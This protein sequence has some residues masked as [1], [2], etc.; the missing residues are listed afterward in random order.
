[1]LNVILSGVVT[2]LLYGLVGLSLVVVYRASKVMN[3]A[4]GGAGVLVAYVA[5]DLLRGGLPYWLVLPTCVAIG[6]LLGGLL[7]LLVARRMRHQA[8]IAVALATLGAMLMVEGAVG[9]HWGFTPSGLTPVLADSGSLRIGDVAVSAN[10]LF[11]IGVSIVATAL[12]LFLIQRTRFGLGMRAASSGPMT[13]ELMGLDV[14]RVRLSA[15]I[16][17]GAYGCLAALLVIPLTYLSPTSFTPFLL[18]AFAAVVLG[19]LT[20]VLGVV[21]GAVFFGVTVNL[22]AV[23]VQSGLIA[24]YTFIGVALILLFRP[25]GLF[26]RG[27]TEIDEPEL[28]QASGRGGG[29]VIPTSAEGHDGSR[30]DGTWS[31]RWS[32]FAGWI[33]LAGALALVPVLGA[34]PDVY[35]VGTILASFVG[36]LGLNVVA[37]FSGQV[38]LANGAMA[39]IGA[40]TTA[41][42]VN[43]EMALLPALALAALAGACGGLVL[44][45]PATRLSGIYLLMFTLMFALSIRELILVFDDI[46]GGAA[47]AP[48]FSPAHVNTVDQYW[49]VLGFT[50]L[51]A[52]LVL[53][54][55]ASPLGRSWRA[56][57]DSPVAAR[58]LGYNPALVKI[59][60]FAFGNALVGLSGG[61]AGLLIGY[62][63]P[64]NFTIFVGVFALL[65]VVLGGPGSVLG[66]LIGAA[67]IVLVPRYATAG[68]DIPVPLVFGTALVIVLMFAPSG[69]AP[70][71]ERLW[72]GLIRTVL[73]RARP[74]HTSPLAVT[75]TAP[76]SDAGPYGPD[77]GMKAGQD[78]ARSFL[79]VNVDRGAREETEGV[80]L[81]RVDQVNAGYEAGHVL[82]DFSMSVHEGEVVALLGANGAG[83]STLLRAVSGLIPVTDG[84]IEWAGETIRG[85][86]LRT[87]HA[88]A[89]AGICHVPEGRGIFPDLTVEEN[90]TM[91]TFAQTD[92]STD[93][94]SRM[95]DMFPVLGER[96]RQ[97]AGTLSGGQQQMLA[98]ARALIGQPRLLM[99]DE[100]SLG[101]AP[102]VSEQ[103]FA[104]LRDIA[105]SGVSILLVEQNARAAL[106]LA[107]HGYVLGRG[108]VA[109]SGPAPD[110][111]NHPSLSD[112]YLAVP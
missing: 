107:D 81:L 12:L 80:V 50:C 73:P 21:V 57:R 7:E 92:N 36:V 32:R 106:E 109:L 4:L 35:L 89:R 20:S 55:A 33:L 24:T 58:S 87:P 75:M 69:I 13:A 99:L 31:A 74:R 111:L 93:E 38:S 5:Q 26:G 18:T 64:D 48:L 19:G 51:C 97:R 62:I 59:G 71:L 2:G 30:A 11:I 15:W 42:F 102:V 29:R 67:F 1:M 22:L 40:Y 63:G 34:E 68:S 41:H 8:H 108:T 53:A 16:I 70:T 54:A 65:A 6:A 86:R 82:R 100:P 37:G 77:V 43:N 105:R 90:L 44:G 91:G 52:F 95:L 72:S 9:W 96:L 3:F 101:L 84:T 94:R 110:L 17:G 104:S 78:A 49:V 46:T 10:R 103:V 66:S 88:I 83:K 76:T 112:A 27:E 60:A 45:L 98:I 39:A 23:Y 61:L 85:R 56:V 79:A 14:S 28:S 47:G 25:H